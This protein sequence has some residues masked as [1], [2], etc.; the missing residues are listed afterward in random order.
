M[1]I[2]SNLALDSAESN[3]SRTEGP[4]KIDMPWTALEGGRFTPS[5]AEGRGGFNVN[6]IIKHTSKSMLGFNGFV[7]KGV[8]GDQRPIIDK[9][10]LNCERNTLHKLAGCR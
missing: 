8:V 1:Q 9:N 7:P 3:S 10:L 6:P 4:S 5:T 2:F